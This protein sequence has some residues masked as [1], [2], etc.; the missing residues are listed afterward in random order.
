M[1]V[2]VIG[3]AFVDLIVPV[4][5]INPGETYHRRI[6]MFIGGLANVA[7]QISKLGERAKFVG[8]IGNDP[9][10]K[11]LKQ[12][13]KENG[14]EDLIIID[15]EAPTGL[16]ISL[17]H[18]NGERTMI[19]S[20]GANDNLSIEDVESRLSEIKNSK[21]VYFSGY[22]LLREKTRSSV[23]FCIKKCHEEGL[24][25]YFNPGA[26]NIIKEEF[27][28]IIKRFVDVLILNQ[29][30]AKVLVDT[31]LESL[32][33]LAKLVIV[34]RGGGGC[35]IIGKEKIVEVKTEKIFVKD[36]TGAG[37]AF[38]AGFIAGKLMNL[39]LIECAKLGNKVA[40]SFLKEKERRLK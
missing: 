25:I 23:L 14:A 40:K 11:Y 16:C 30:E 34:T 29:D 21:I 26:P 9:F 32:I 4:Y 22:S 19:A 36:S 12:S 20:R 10:G 8:K 7:L 39:S 27:K 2:T 31:N 17:V 1:S 38:S 37:D 15:S 28:Q 13:L 6:E 24:E 3:E 18:E 33:D 5:N 35:T